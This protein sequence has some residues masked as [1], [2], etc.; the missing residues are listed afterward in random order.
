MNIPW[1]KCSERMPFRLDVIV[2]LGGD[3]NTPGYEYNRWSSK[4]LKERFLLFPATSRKF[5]KDN[6][7]WTPYTPEVWEELNR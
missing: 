6:A 7:L 3:L 1:V 4:E 2:T 5:W